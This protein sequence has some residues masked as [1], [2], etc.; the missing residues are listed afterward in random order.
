MLLPSRK[1]TEK[2]STLKSPSNGPGFFKFSMATCGR[3]HFIKAA[4]LVGIILVL[5]NLY[6]YRLESNTTPTS[7][8]LAH[9][10]YNE[11]V[12]FFNLGNNVFNFDKFSLSQ[13]WPKRTRTSSAISHLSHQSPLSTNGTRTNSISHL[14][15][16]TN[17]HIAHQN[18]NSTF[19]TTNTSNTNNEISVKTKVILEKDISNLLKLNSSKSNETDTSAS[20]E[21]LESLE[22][23]T[24]SQLVEKLMTK[25]GSNYCPPIPPDLGNAK[26]CKLIASDFHFI[27]IY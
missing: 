7:M 19:L 22:S 3:A 4:L 25:F 14:T 27:L 10:R 21:H 15:N 8:S 11:N 13:Q 16:S 24:K 18:D 23:S 2:N 20:S 17:V 9:G 12:F 26:P 5:L 1:S 6:N